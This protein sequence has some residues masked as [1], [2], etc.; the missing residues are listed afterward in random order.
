MTHRRDQ[1]VL[2]LLKLLTL[3]HIQSNFE[4]YQPS[5]GPADGFVETFVPAFVLG[6]EKFPNDRGARLAIVSELLV[7][8]KITRMLNTLLQLAVAFAPPPILPEKICSK[9]VYIKELITLKIRNID[10]GIH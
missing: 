8:A 4:P 1:I 3:G 7:R 2:D 6:V 5:I 10:N 9:A